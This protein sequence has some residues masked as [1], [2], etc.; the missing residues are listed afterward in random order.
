MLKLN[1]KIAELIG[2][3][4]GD[5]TLYKTNRGLVWELRGALD[6]RDY[7]DNNV[8]PLL[9]LIFKKKFAAKFR[10]GGKNGCYG[11]QISK[12]EVSSF[13]LDYG[14]HYGCKTYN[15]RIPEYIF[16]SSKKIK[17]AFIRGLFDTDGCLRFDKNRT[18][19]NYYPKIE[20]VSTSPKL[21]DDLSCLLTELDFR[22]YIWKDNK[23]SKLCVAGK[24]MLSK[25]M[26]EIKPK[27]SKHLNKY[28]NFQRLEQ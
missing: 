14:F 18:Q 20:F 13:F 19:I 4:V 12:K 3:H 7:Y 10:S 22:N 26:T 17:F 27:N 21:I 23:H 9:L 28:E 11:V 24:T 1:S 2:M 15:V 6:E 5:G 16:N 25:W 8:V